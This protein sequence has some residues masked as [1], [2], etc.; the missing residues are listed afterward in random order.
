[1]C[2]GFPVLRKSATIQDTIVRIGELFKNCGSQI[3][4][5]EAKREMCQD[6][7]LRNVFSQSLKSLLSLLSV[8]RIK[9]GFGIVPSF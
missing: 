2:R 1:M 3:E 4:C 7:S 8:A 9:F 6:R 5:I